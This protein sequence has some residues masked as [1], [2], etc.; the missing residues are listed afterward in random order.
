MAIKIDRYPQLRIIA[1]NRHEDDFITEEEALALYE[2]NWVYVDQDH[3]CV[4]E[5]AFIDRI[6]DKHGNGVLN[7]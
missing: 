7:V 6:A 1:W 2:R 5:R 4:D 3:L